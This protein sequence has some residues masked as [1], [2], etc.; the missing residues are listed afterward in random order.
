MLAN[1]LENYETWS[2][3]YDSDEY[4]FELDAEAAKKRLQSGEDPLELYKDWSHWTFRLDIIVLRHIV[5]EPILEEDE[6][7]DDSE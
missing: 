6:E 2:L 3:S 7:D 4:H 1:A 5:P